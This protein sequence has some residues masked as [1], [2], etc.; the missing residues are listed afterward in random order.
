MNNSTKILGI[1]IGGTSIKASI[2][3]IDNGWGQ[4]FKPVIIFKKNC[5]LIGWFA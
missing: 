2:V 5:S 3:D 1:D 4:F